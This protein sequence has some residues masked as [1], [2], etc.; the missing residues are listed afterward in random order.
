MRL[1]KNC[2][3]FALPRNFPRGGREDEQLELIIGEAVDGVRPVSGFSKTKNGD[4]TLMGL[5]TAEGL[6]LLYKVGF[7]L[8][9]A[10]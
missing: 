9:W 5:V 2:V 3:C 1:K 10:S 4:S 6:L 8:C 7:T